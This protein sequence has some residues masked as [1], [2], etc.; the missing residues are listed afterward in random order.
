MTVK[1]DER[2]EPKVVLNAGVLAITAPGG[3]RLDILGAEKDI[4][5]KQKSFGTN[6]G[7]AW[8]IVMPEGD[9]VVKVRKKD[10]S[11]VEGTASVKAG[12][13]A[14]VTVE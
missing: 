1:G 11:V 13:R 7:E 2:V 12:Q 6:Y 5:G 3:D 14:E 10:K 8:Q 9:Y 4:A